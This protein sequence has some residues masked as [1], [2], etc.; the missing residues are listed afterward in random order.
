M[1]ETLEYGLFI[2][3]RWASPNGASRFTTQNPANG[4]T[5]GSFVSARPEDATRA[6]DAA[7]R[8]FPAWRDTPAPKRGEMLLK[9]AAVMR[10]RKESIGRVVTKEMGKVIAEGR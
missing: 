6:V 4:E 2:D 3:G 9:V 10:Q 5:L 7:A 1:A 8:A